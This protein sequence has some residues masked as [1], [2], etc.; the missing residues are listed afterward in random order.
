MEDKPIEKKEEEKEE[1]LSFENGSIIANKYKISAFIDEGAFGK[2]YK[3]E[4][5]DDN[6]KE[7][8]LKVL[9]K[10]KTS[11]ENIQVFKH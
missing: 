11:R 7:Y 6:N 10:E 9:I 5:I 1:E 2:V 8:E 4:D 3:V